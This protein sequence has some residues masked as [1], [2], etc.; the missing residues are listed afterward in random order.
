M[1]FG[2][3]IRENEMRGIGRLYESRFMIAQYIID[4]SPNDS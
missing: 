1:R 4:L 3:Y 2:E